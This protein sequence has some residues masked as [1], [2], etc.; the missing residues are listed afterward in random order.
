MTA[1]LIHKVL[2][3]EVWTNPILLN[4]TSPPYNCQLNYFMHPQ[5]SQMA[6]Q[7]MTLTVANG[8]TIRAEQSR[9]NTYKA[10]CGIL[11]D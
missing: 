6:A 9:I 5:Q 2:L 4:I 8:H 11:I 1:F 7:L 10:Q 3:V